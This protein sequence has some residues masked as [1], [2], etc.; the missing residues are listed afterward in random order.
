[1][2]LL[3]ELV[4]ELSGMPFENYIKMHILDPLDLQNTRTYLPED[5]YC[6]DL[7]IGY[8]AL[9]QGDVCDLLARQAGC[10]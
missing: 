10:A 3:G 6:S 9:D 4:E 7:A 2:T 1:M 5:L 8:N